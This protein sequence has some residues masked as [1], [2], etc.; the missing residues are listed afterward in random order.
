MEKQENKLYI[1]ILTD[2]P[3]SL[4]KTFK[5]KDTYLNQFLVRRAKHHQEELLATTYLLFYENDDIE[6]ELVGYYTLSCSSVT[7]TEYVKSNF[8]RNK[9]YEDYPAILIGRL[10][11][12]KKYENKGFGSFLLDSIKRKA[13][14]NQ[15]FAG[16]FLILDAK[17]E[18]V[19][20]YKKNHFD[21]WTKEDQNEDTRLMY[22]DLL[23]MK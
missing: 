19:D 10:A 20:F 18:A 15:G 5:S 17:K 2:E 21:F 12:S 3:N 13:I 11:I 14:D 22:F 6:D 7:A 1:D 8:H 9:Q 4:L 16:R 23:Q